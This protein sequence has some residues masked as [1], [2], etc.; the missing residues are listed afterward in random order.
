[1]IKQIISITTRSAVFSQ[2]VGL[3]ERAEPDRA[4]MLRIL[5]YHRVAPP[6]TELNLSP[7]L[8]SASPEGFDE[9]MRYLAEHYH[10]ISVQDLL[11]FYDK[12]V[13]LP[14][15]AVMVTFDDAYSDFAEYAWPILKRYQMPVAL[16]VPT[17]YPDQPERIFWWDR[18]Y[19]AIRD[20]TCPSLDTTIGTLGMTSTEDRTRAFKKLREHV[21][22]LPH[23][24]AMAW[25]DTVYSQL[26]AP[27]QETNSVLSWDKLRELHQEGVTLGAHTRTHPMIHRITLQEAWM[28]AVGAQHD[29]ESNIG[30]VAPIFAY[31]GGGFSDDVVNMLDKEGF[32]LAFTTIRGLNDMRSADRL[33]LRRLNVG[34]LAAPASIRAQLLTRWKFLN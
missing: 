23:E 1:L 34:R 32:A 8:L 26:G 11:D 19:H 30:S 16:F 28:E 9:Q 10:P 33:R 20:T 22:T 17:A 21:K 25:L 6:T 12:H 13:P 24:E 27:P 18:L 3:I 5:T 2:F 31:P 7:A 29:L 14:A 4:D 15:R